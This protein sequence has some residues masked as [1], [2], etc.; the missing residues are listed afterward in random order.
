[1]YVRI[2]S[3]KKLYVMLSVIGKIYKIDLVYVFWQIVIY[4]YY[5]L[6]IVYTYV[7]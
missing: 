2:Y 1:M 3:I 5:M 7:H 4:S 6:N